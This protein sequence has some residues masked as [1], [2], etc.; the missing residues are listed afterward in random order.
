[1]KECVAKHRLILPKRILCNCLKKFHQYF[2]VAN[3]SKE[4]LSSLVTFENVLYFSKEYICIIFGGIWKYV[5]YA[6]F[7]VAGSCR[8]IEKSNWRTNTGSPYLPTPACLLSQKYKHKYKNTKILKLTQ[9]LF[10]QLSAFTNE[11]ECEHKYRYESTNTDMKKN[12]KNYEQ[13]QVQSTM[14][15]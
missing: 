6:A 7:W 5:V 1:M 11:D 13:I 4:Y 12:T 8:L 3:L 2:L 9:N 10:H 15:L 14:Q